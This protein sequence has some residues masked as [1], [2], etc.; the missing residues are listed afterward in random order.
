MKED[1]DAEEGSGNGR[2]KPRQRTPSNELHIYSEA[3]LAQFKR[4]DMIADAELLD[5]EINL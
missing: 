4:K 3:E 2:R 1:P 5:G